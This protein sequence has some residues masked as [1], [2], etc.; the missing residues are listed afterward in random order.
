ML[1]RMGHTPVVRVTRIDTGP[2]ELSLK[3]ES[4]NPT[5]SIKDRIGLAMI[6]AAEREGKIT[7]GATLVEASAG[8]TGVSLAWVAAQK[9][10]TMI[11]VVSDK[12]SQEKRQ[13]L[14]ELGAEVVV[15]RSDVHRGHPEYYQ[16]V[17]ARLAQERGAFFVDQFNNPANPL[18]HESG[19]ATE[20][21]QQM[22]E[23]LDAI[24]VGA[25][26]GGTLTGLGRF[27]KDKGVEMILADPIGSVYAPFVQTGALVEA[28]PW[29][30]EGVGKD[31]IPQNCDLSLVK[32]AYAIADRDSVHMARELRR[33]EGILAGASSGMLLCAA[34][35]YCREQ[36]ESKR[37][38]TF[39][40][41]SGN[42]YLSKIFN[43]DWL[44]ENGLL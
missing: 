39:V 8:N 25:G 23:R 18:A 32:K 20:L 4:E 13:H 30:I 3:L 16:D 28:T 5:G 11:V 27:F 31:F 9:N 33:Q 44:K 26:T 24:V 41:D 6:E 40:C 43:D 15:T 22:D 38:L 12:A 29:L 2:C 17:A 37:V 14:R 36:S 21:W 19:T 35:R 10:Y 34:L 42:K 7:P 1:E